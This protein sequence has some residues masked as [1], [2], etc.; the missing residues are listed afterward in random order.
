MPRA[1]AYYIN[2]IIL[3]HPSSRTTAGVWVFSESAVSCAPTDVMEVGG[4]ISNALIHSKDNLPHP[5]HW[6]GFFAPVLQLSG[7][8]TFGDFMK[9]AKCV[10]IDQQGNSITFTPTKNLGTDDGFEP[11]TAR[12]C[13]ANAERTDDLGTALLTAFSDSD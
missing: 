2:G 12:A 9:L 5:T 13:Q 11:I 1:T 4:L 3:L 7:S 10:E 8:R 6:K